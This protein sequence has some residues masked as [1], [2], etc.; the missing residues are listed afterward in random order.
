MSKALDIWEEIKK[1]LADAEADFVKFDQK[2]VK[3]SGGRLRKVAQTSKKLWQDLRI[4][5][6]SK[7]K[8]K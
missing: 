4:E 7:L 2:G 6:M 5:I 1:T 3:A 8:A